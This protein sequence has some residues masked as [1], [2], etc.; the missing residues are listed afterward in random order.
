MD[1]FTFTYLWSR[2]SKK[3]GQFNEFLVDYYIEEI[4]EHFPKAESVIPKIFLTGGNKF[5]LASFL[6]NSGLKRKESYDEYSAC[7]DAERRDK[8]IKNFFVSKTTKSSNVIEVG[9]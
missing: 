1:P 9:I 8:L 6:T 2:A 5:A 3:G 4:A 7:R